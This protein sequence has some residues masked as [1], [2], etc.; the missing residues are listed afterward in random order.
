MI[1]PLH[2]VSWFK[3]FAKQCIDNSNIV[4][5]KELPCRTLVETLKNKSIKSLLLI[6]HF[7]VL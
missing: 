2:I 6:Q 1:A 7:E 4:G 3:T 5:E